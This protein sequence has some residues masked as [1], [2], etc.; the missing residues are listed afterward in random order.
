MN[1]YLY[2]TLATIVG[3]ATYILARYFLL[4]NFDI[5]ATIILAAV[6]WIGNFIYYK[7]LLKNPSCK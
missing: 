2:S 5:A 3:T 7:F 4:G 1:L 6:L